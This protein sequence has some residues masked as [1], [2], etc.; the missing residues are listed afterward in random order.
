M[1][2]IVKTIT[3]GLFPFI[4]L[5]G[6]Y[7]IV[8]GHLSPGGSFPGG[9]MVVVGLALIGIVFGLKK[10][11]RVIKEDTAHIMEGVMA[12]FMV[13]LVLMETLVRNL[14]APTGFLFHLWSAQQVLLLNMFG[15]IMVVMALSIVV[16]LLL[17]E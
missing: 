16:F 5:F 11:E 10:A 1:D 9:A 6:V 3:K 15:G 17:K 4:L 14:L 7:V 12:F 2:I 13:F 8:H